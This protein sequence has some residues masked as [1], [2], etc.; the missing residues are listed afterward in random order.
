MNQPA[1]MAA[2]LAQTRIKRRLS[3]TFLFAFAFTLIGQMIVGGICACSNN[4]IPCLD[5][6]SIGAS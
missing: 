6:A 4:N 1:N 2:T 5:V 3:F